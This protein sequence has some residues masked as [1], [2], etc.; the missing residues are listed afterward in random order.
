LS[1]AVASA[2]FPDDNKEYLSTDL[3]M[4]ETVKPDF[5][6]P[7]IELPGYSAFTRICH[8]CCDFAACTE[9]KAA[10]EPSASQGSVE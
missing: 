4:K 10:R 2:V 1:E 6:F 7:H 9:R 8:T 3:L 5:I